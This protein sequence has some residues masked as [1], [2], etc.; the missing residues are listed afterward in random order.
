[1]NMNS[2]NESVKKKW[3]DY[4]HP[5]QARP[6]L[7][8]IQ[9][10]ARIGDLLKDFPTTYDFVLIKENQDVNMQPGKIY[11]CMEKTTY[12]VLNRD[13]H[14]IKGDFKHGLDDE[15][16]N[17]YLT[18]E[19]QP[20]EFNTVIDS[21]GI[22]CHILEELTKQGL[23]TSKRNKYIATSAIWSGRVGCCTP[24]THFI[25]N[26]YQIG[27]GIVLNPDHLR[28]GQADIF[29]L[30]SDNEHSTEVRREE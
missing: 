17:Y 24:T 22:R 20:Y 13:N 9:N 26:Q 7:F 10:T 2:S 3:D 14:I 18:M 25:N 6:V 19:Q 15:I 12:Y 30:N 23:R 5:Y 28:L 11:V 27:L 8:S 21:F 4:P 29:A 16:T 1:M